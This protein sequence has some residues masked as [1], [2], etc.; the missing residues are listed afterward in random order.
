MPASP[1]S[2]PGDI[3][4]G[5]GTLLQQGRLIAPVDYH[6]TIP[7]QTH[8]LINPT[9]KLR[10]DYENHAGGFILLHPDDADTISLTGYTLELANKSKKQITVQRRYKEIIHQGQPRVSF[11]VILVAG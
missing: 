10:L 11:W 2:N 7:G 4:E 8:F 5:H 3:L 9:G 6:L 1:F